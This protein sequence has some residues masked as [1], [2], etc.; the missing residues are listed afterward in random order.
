M[1]GQ[2]HQGKAR[3]DSLPERVQQSP[4]AGMRGLP[5]DRLKLESLQRGAG[6][7]AMRELLAGGEGRPLPPALRHD[8]EQRFG[9]NFA[10]VRIHDSPRTGDA[11]E[12]LSANALTRG[13]DIAF[14]HGRF[15]PDTMDG[16]RLLGHELAHVVQQSRGG[17]QPVRDLASSLEQ[18]AEQ[19][20]DVAAGGGSP[21][22][23][24]ASGV[25]V[26]ADDN[27][28]KRQAPIYNAGPTQSAGLPSNVA[29][30]TLNTEINAITAA[31]TAPDPREGPLTL[32]PALQL[33]VRDRT[34]P[35]TE[36]GLLASYGGVAPWNRSA[37]SS[38]PGSSYQT[39]SLFYTR[40]DG[41][42]YNPSSDDPQNSFGNWLNAGFVFGNPGAGNNWNP[43]VTDVGAYTH[44]WGN[45]ELDLNAGATAQWLGSV[46]NRNV[47]GFV[48]PY[49][50]ANYAR[51]LGS[52]DQV[53]IEG[54]IGANAGLGG[55]TDR[56]AADPAVADPSVPASLRW[57]AGLG[58]QHV[59]GDTTWGVEA[60]VNGEA[61]PNIPN[62]QQRRLPL[63]FG[64][65]WT[66]S[67]F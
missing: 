58:Y 26:M 23:A 63:G 36:Q 3:T 40:H 21:A 33:H 27:E 43:S 13:N 65:N 28:K 38:V 66:V 61:L 45:N 17:A 9:E 42:L 16:K 6:N 5:T 31:Q 20:G 24:G 32:N 57:G 30:D 48:S 47:R 10:A 60:V 34:S 8:M 52:S 2:A 67:S 12:R 55:A 44:Q 11:A 39:G 46:N 35:T 14:G 51:Q 56:S 18:D 29:T 49:L 25:G 54:L 15:A 50:A 7:A 37:V 19:A 4:L 41:Q 62:A 1:R 22:P 53:N 64:V 59:S